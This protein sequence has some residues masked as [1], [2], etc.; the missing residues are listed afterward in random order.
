MGSFAPSPTC[1]TPTNFATCACGNPWGTR[2]DHACAQLDEQGCR[3]PLQYARMYH[4]RRFCMAHD[5]R[6]RYNACANL[7]PCARMSARCSTRMYTSTHARIH[8][9]ARGTS[10]DHTSLYD[11]PHTL[12]FGKSGRGTNNLRSG[13]DKFFPL[14]LKSKLE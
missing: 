5:T 11:T 3:K 7:H 6:T 13:P 12:L 8:T 1:P 2:M 9:R 4:L 14:S 10:S